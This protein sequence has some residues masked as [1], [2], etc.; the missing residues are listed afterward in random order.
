[1]LEEQAIFFQGERG[2]QQTIET[3]NTLLVDGPASVRIIFGK[4]EVFAFHIKPETRIVVREAKRMPFFV[5]EKALFDISL[6]VNASLETIA[7]RSTIPESW[8]KPIEAILNSKNKPVVILI[9]GKIDSG[10]SSYCTYLVN[11]LVNEKCRVAV[12]DGDL[13]QSDIG[14]SGTIG[15]AV[16]SKPITELHNLKLENAFFVGVTSPILGIREVIEGLDAM[17]AQILKETIDFVVVNTDG[18]V[19]GDVAIRYKTELIREI[20]PDFII[21]VPQRNEL[22]QLIANIEKTPIILVEPS[23][24]L[25]PRN[26]EKRKILR[27]MTYTRY[28]KDAKLQC[29]PMSQL[30]IEPKTAIPKS[31]EP[32]KGLLV[33]LFASKNEFLGI[34]VLREI[35]RLRK[36]LKVQTSVLVK[37]HRLVIGKVC[38]NMKLQEIQD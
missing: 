6:G 36:A 7:G 16:T 26:P 20:K 11:K 24:S 27:E 10:K 22:D 14:P 19:A 12:L 18:W 5:R 3:N 34:G 32:E 35:N 37:P 25:N 13:G 2:L 8:N 29:Y 30:I 38:L 4:V 15:Y 17:L 21:G 9:L 1:L 33:G 23:S 28:L 31:Q